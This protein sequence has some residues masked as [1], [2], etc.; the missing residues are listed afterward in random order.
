MVIRWLVNR[1]LL[2]HGIVVNTLLT[3]G[4]CSI[5][6]DADT[7]LLG[8]RWKVEALTSFD[9][10]RNV[11]R[12]LGKIQPCLDL[13]WLDLDG[14]RWNGFCWPAIGHRF[15]TLRTAARRLVIV[16]GSVTAGELFMAGA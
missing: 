7:L 14:C 6:V 16:D 3:G 2:K 5:V 1:V 12:D 10:K 4:P 15:T 13:R 9:L 8:V 11:V